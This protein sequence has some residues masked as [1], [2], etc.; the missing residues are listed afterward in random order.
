MNQ[1]KY[2]KIWSKL[3][4]GDS[5]LHSTPY[6]MDI[7]EISEVE[8]MNNRLYWEIIDSLRYMIATSPDICYTVTKLSQDLMK[9]TTILLTKA[10]HVLCYLKA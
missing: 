2:I 6:E 8:F 9:Q 4:M 7:N 1:S 10:K 5:K 3:N